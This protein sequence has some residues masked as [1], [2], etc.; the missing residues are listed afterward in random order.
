VILFQER[1]PAANDRLNATKDALAAAGADFATVARDH[2]DGMQALQGG[3]LG[4]RTASQLPPDVAT[5][6]LATAVGATTDPVQ[7]DSAT[8]PGAASGFYIEKVEEK[9]TRTPDGQEAAIVAATAFDAWYADQKT[10][11]TTG[12]VIVVDPAVFKSSSSTSGQ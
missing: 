1:I 4:W 11:A 10:K 12:K 6:V 5:K 3:E 7:V 9:A 2:S 8:T